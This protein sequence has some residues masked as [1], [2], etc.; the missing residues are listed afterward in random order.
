MLG[1]TNV[2]GD[3]P[4]VKYVFQIILIKQLKKNFWANLLDRCLW[5]KNQQKPPKK[6][7]GSLPKEKE[8]QYD[9]DEPF[10]E[11]IDV[12][13]EKPYILPSNNNGE[14]SSGNIFTKIF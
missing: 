4:C 8:N 11:D 2:V 10:E 12:K 14:L 6:R 3:H 7:R 13:V 9:E 1:I 5:E